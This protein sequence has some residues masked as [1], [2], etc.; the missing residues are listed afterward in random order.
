MYLLL[1]CTC[2]EIK[3][4]V[5]VGGGAVEAVLVVGVEEVIGERLVVVLVAEEDG[6]C[7]GV[8]SSMM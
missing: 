1:V 6:S 5:G 8:S 7:V 2:K 3:S 4:C